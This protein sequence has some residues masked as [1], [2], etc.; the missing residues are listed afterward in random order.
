M[1]GFF[2]KIGIYAHEG[3][4]YEPED[5]EQLSSYREDKKGQ[6]LEEGITE[7][8]AMSSF[9]AAG[10]SY[11]NHDLEMIPVYTF[12]SMFGFQRVM[13]LIWAAGDSQTRGFLIG[14]TSGRTTLA[15]EGL[16]H[17][18]GHSQLLA[19]T[20]P[21][22]I[23]YDPTFA[24]ELA[25]IF[26][27]GLRRMHDEQENIFYYL[28]TMNENYKHPEIP[29][30]CEKGILKG[31][32]LFKEFNNKGK[33]KV[34]LLGSGTILREMISAAKILSEEYSIDSDV[35]SVTSFNEL[36]K[37]GMKIEREN[38]LNPTEK[39]KKSYVEEC[40][41]GRDGIIIAAT[42]YMRSFADQIRPYTSKNFYSFGTDG[43][44]RSDSRKN[45]RKF[46]EVDKE[47]IVTYTLSALAKEQLISST[48]A[49]KAMKK[50][51]INKDKPM[52]ITL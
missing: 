49:E 25:I 4:K 43:Y 45:L 48:F 3:Q 7:T 18:D 1:E 13:D 38:L 26:Q 31:M 9:I 24:Y 17:Q 14:A 10:T 46:F 19:S 30:N 40:L 33:I 16:Q 12:Y 23:S 5:A 22:C 39:P 15:G 37:D 27:D 42:D 36:R 2:R 52:P 6:V 50:Y 32:Y 21:N 11:T 51:K 28:T 20:V 8:G 29:K 47:H 35:W 34:Q 44:G 41:G